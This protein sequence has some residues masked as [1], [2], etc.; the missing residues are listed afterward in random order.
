M[1]IIKN[2]NIICSFC[3]K[4]KSDKNNFF[5][6][7]KACICHKCLNIFIK[8]KKNKKKI[9]TNNL[10][11]IEPKKIKKKLDE[12]IIGQNKAKKILSVA[13]YN[14]FFKIKNIK[15]NKTILDKSNIL[16]IG[17]SGSGKTLLV[18][19]L[20]KII[21]FPIVI[22]DATTLTQAG[23]V[24]ED[25]ENILQR[26]LYKCNF[27]IEKTQKGIIFI[28]EIDKIAKKSQNISITRDVSGEGVQQS[29]LKII[30]GTISS[31][32]PQGGR[33]HPQQEFIQINTK[34]IL[35]IFGGTFNGI[36]KIIEKR[37][38]KKNNIG[39]NSKIKKNFIYN[40]I[41]KKIEPN[42]L[43]NFGFIPEFIG[44]IPIITYL[45]ELNKK[46]L[47][48]ILIKPKN[49]IIEQ[50]KFLFKLNNINL[51]FEK[52]ALI[53]IV[54]KSINKKIGARGLR[55]IIE[56]ILVDLMYEIPSMKGIKKIIINKLVIEKK[57]KPIIISS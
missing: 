33:K 45:N 30:E 8:I 1:N 5:I 49:S 17:P 15:E 47:L 36:N 53:E 44:R 48:E 21:N 25:V 12:F 20:S 27:D 26:L 19:T 23:Y 11:N 42:D 7:I 4:N 43:I 24:G 18:K 32:P 31:V 34:N 40:D 6:G 50:F 38:N 10:K 35:F 28:D 22:T 14:H 54:N 39:F 57:N 2:K 13:M 52:E 16:L 46:N 3:G 9:K 37:L 56:N 51:I 55:N 29:L 41:L